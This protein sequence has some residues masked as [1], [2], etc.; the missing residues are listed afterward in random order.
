MM[1]SLTDPKRHHLPG[2]DLEQ[3]PVHRIPPRRARFSRRVK[4]PKPDSFTSSSAASVVR[5]RINE[6]I[7]QH[8]AFFG[9]QA[10]VSGRW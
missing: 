8:R 3:F 5:D 4:F 2:G 1:Q 7:D 9:G 6:G 10:T